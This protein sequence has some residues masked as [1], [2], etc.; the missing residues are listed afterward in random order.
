M[1]Q[2]ISIDISKEYNIDISEYRAGPR[3]H[4]ACPPV[5]GAS[6]RTQRAHEPIALLLQL[7]SF[8]RESKVG[9]NETI[10]KAIVERVIQLLWI[11][12]TPLPHNPRKLYGNKVRFSEN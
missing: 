4:R 10:A 6:R 2:N 7:Q 3:F 12:N 1:Y 11:R 5:H 8:R 9:D